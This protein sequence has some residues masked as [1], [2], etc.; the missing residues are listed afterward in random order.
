MRKS[1]WN[2]DARNLVNTVADPAAG[3]EGGKKHENYAAASGGH[4]F[5]T[6][7]TK[8]TKGMFLHLSVSHSVHRRGGVCLSAC[9]DS[10]SWEPQ[11]QIQIFLSDSDLDTG[12]S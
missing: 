2:W 4:L 12:N 8:F 11:S 9:W 1:L 3:K 10:G 7:K 6:R 5:T